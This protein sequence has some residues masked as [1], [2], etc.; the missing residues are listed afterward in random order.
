MHP[1]RSGQAGEKRLLLGNEA[2][3]RGALEAGVAL[4]AA[5]PG[6]PSSEIADRFYQISQE[7]ELYFEYSTNEKVSLEVAAGAAASGLRAMCSMKHVGVNVAADT[8]MT[9]AYSGVRGGLVLV[10]AD[11]PSLFSSQNEQDN[12]YYA[13]LSGLPMLEPSSAQEAK[14]MTRY[15]FELSERLSLPVILRTTTRINHSRGVVVLGEVT[16]PQRQG[17]FNKN[18]FRY[19]MVPAVA[20]QAHGI[21]LAQ[22]AKA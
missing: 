13:T 5:Y 15:A 20:R 2:I 4:A 7:S 8:L 18:P 1:L 11:D 17:H 22:Q 10:S 19:V 12:R 21:L 9:L 3:V 14:D 16:P 6:T